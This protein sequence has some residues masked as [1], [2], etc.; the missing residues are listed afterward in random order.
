MITIIHRIGEVETEQ[1]LGEHL[2]TIGVLPPD[3]PVPAIPLEV[4]W[5][6]TGY[7]GMIYIADVSIPEEPI[8]VWWY[9]RWRFNRDMYPDWI[10]GKIED[11]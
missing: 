11:Y 8:T 2:Y 3:Y 9:D 4:H 1:G 10:L 6:D 7:R 5:W